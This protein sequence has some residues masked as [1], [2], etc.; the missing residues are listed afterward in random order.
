MSIVLPGAAD[1][2]VVIGPT[3]SGKTVGGAWVLTKQNFAKRPWIAIDFKDEE[4]WDL[5]GTPPMR[6]LKLGSMPGKLGFYRMQVRPGQEE[7]LE[8]WLWKVWKKENIGLFVDEVSLIPQK[9]AFKAILRQGRSKRIPVISCTQRPVDCDR[10]V[11][12]ESQFRMFYGIEDPRDWLVI[13]G[14]FKHG[15]VERP[16]P[17][18]W[19]YWYDAK[20]KTCTTLSPVPPPPE[21]AKALRAVSPRNWTL[22]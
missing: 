16:L 5:V 9:A 12:S 2:T 13:R 8:Y 6:D 19:C 21:I 4:L 15:D 1:R 14:L 18:Y 22:V 11:F 17:P 7:Q 3:G 10:E 20:N